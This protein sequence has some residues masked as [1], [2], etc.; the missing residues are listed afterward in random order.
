MEEVKATENLE[1][2]VVTPEKPN[3]QAQESRIEA[4]IETMS[5]VELESLAYRI[6]LLRD[7]NNMALNRISEQIA[8][9]KAAKK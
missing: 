5:V 2:D 9:R 3:V 8:L 6:I 7:G 4:N 1:K